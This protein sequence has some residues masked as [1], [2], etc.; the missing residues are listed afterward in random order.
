MVN[1]SALGAD[2]RLPAASSAVPSAVTAAQPQRLPLY[3]QLSELL[4]RE[5]DAG[6]WQPGERLPTEAAL[7]EHLGVAVGTLR[8]SLAELDARGLLLRRQGSGTYVRQAPPAEPR[9]S[10]YGFFRLERLDGGGGLPTADLLTFDRLA[11][12]AGLPALGGAADDTPQPVWR[13]RRLRR[14]DG[15]PAALEDICFDARGREA[16]SVADLH[17]SLYHF[18][19]QRL[20]FW[21]AQVEDHLGLGTVPAWAP[22]GSGLQPG[23]PAVQVQRR[24]WSQHGVLEEVSTTWVD[25]RVARY[26]ARWR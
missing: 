21:I 4:T 8:K 15:Q 16:L 1:E 24:S 14:L 13:V 22:P 20:D 6:R 10:I 11:R 23:Q 12:P 25:S 17:E 18:Y 19:A 26:S 7:A 3:L 5:I 2:P 9:R